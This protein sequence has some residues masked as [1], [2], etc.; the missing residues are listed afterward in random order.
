[1]LPS[2]SHFIESDDGSIASPVFGCV[3]DE[4]MGSYLSSNGVVRSHDGGKTW[5]DFSFVFRTQP[6]GPD[7]Y[8]HEPRYS[9]MDIAQ[10]PNGHWVAFSRN[11]RITMGPAGWG[12]AHVAL[13]TDLGRTWRRTGGSLQGVS[14]QKG[15]VLPDGGLTLTWRSTSWQGSGV[16]ITYAEGRSF[17]YLLT[18]PYETV[19]AFMHGT[20]EFVVF[21]M[22]SHRS[23]SSAGIYRWVPN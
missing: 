23:D 6:P 22:K 8:Q 18:G 13:S 10:L 9:E 4:E 21:S 7:D 19:N 2:V 5:G 11:D 16:A 17:D 20:D 1:M 14:Q 3:T 15:V 12:S